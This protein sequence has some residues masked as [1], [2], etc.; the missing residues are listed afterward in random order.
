MRPGHASYV[1][2][3]DDSVNAGLH[4]YYLSAELCVNFGAFF[5]VS[6]W[7]LLISCKHFA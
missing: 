4:V 3:S 1:A 5:V 7:F 6:G 2:D